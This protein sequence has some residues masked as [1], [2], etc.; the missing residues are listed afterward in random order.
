MHSHRK[1]GASLQLKDIL[2]KLKRETE[3]ATK[4]VYKTVYASSDI[5]KA[6]TVLDRLLLTVDRDE[7]SYSRELP[8]ILDELDEPNEEPDAGVQ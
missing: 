4:Q 6:R 2:D 3:P 8:T 7:V 5:E 1:R